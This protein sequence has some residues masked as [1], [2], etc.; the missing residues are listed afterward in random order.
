M[1]NKY[2]VGS[3]QSSSFETLSDGLMYEP[4]MLYP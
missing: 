3:F 1:S 2:L 4:H